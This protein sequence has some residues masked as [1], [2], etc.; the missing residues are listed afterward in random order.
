MASK[1]LTVGEKV[2]KGVSGWAYTITLIDGENAV[3]DGK[4]IAKLSELK[5]VVT[6]NSDGW[7]T[8]DTK[9]GK[10]YY[11]KWDDKEHPVFLFELDLL[12]QQITVNPHPFGYVTGAAVYPAGDFT[13]VKLRTAALTE[14][15][16]VTTPSYRW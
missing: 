9:G 11:V 4:T 12:S 6:K 3:L 8:L 15:N 7:Y 13:P 16:F 10:V 1:M 2:F 14:V 5:S